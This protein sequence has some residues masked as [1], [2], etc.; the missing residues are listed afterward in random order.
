VLS[1]EDRLHAI[2]LDYNSSHAMQQAI[3]NIIDPIE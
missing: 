3:V 1:K 2:P